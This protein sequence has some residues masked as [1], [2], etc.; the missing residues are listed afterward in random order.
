M[1]KIVLLMQE[2]KLLTQRHVLKK[3]FEGMFAGGRYKMLFP[4]GITDS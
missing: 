2:M 4:K 1:V 3:I